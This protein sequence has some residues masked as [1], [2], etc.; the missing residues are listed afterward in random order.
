VKAGR[1]RPPSN[2]LQLRT[3]SPR[4]AALGP[5]VLR[6]ARRFLRRAGLSHVELSISLVGDRAIR[7]LNRRWRAKDKATDVLSFPAGLSPVG[8]G[9][10]PLGDV[11]ISVETARRRCGGRTSA[12]ASEVDRY[13][14]HGLL[15]LLGYDH[16]R[17]ADA[18]KMRAREL[19]LL[20]RAGMLE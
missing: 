17:P 4:G 14:A 10:K 8:F 18:R 2:V 1:G 5:H 11:V 12:V 3:S 6:S 13:L 7:A 15:H 20:G 9:P 16:E 19:A